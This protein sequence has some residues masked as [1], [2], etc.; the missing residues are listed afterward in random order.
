M[1]INEKEYFNIQGASDLLDLSV[2][3]SYKYVKYGVLPFIQ[4]RDKGKLYF[5]KVD[6][7]NHLESGRKSIDK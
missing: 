6:I 7:I 2:R 5:K 3:T 4:H 1:K